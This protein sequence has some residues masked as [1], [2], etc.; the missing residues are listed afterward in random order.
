ME[1]AMSRPRCQYVGDYG[2]CLQDADYHLKI[3]T[4]KRE[5]DK[6]LCEDHVEEE[7]QTLKS[8]IDRIAHE[9]IA[10]EM[11]DKIGNGGKE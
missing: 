9:E 10:Q 7:T 6:D 8:Y 1:R 11:C 3:K 4:D 2:R 5:W